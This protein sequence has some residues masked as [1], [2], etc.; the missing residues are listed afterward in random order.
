[1]SAKF[2]PARG[3][4]IAAAVS[5]STLFATPA[6]AL[7]DDEARRAILDLRAQVKQLSEQNQ[8]ARYQLADRLEMMQREIASMRGEI[9]KLRWEAD[10]AKRADQ[11]QAS[12][13]TIQTGN[14]DEQAAF[15]APMGLFQAGK[16]GEAAAGFAKFRGDYPSSQLTNEAIFYQG[17]SL[18]ATKDFKN[19]ISQLQAMVQKSP[20]DPRSPDALLIVAAAQIELN[21]M[22]G[23]KATLQ[24]IAQDYPQTSAAETAKS[25][26][27]LL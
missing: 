20:A 15:D 1:M 26:L 13:S 8:Q 2:S 16:Y 7:A 5:I 23:A 14:P 12:G 11:N 19:A 27:Q 4:L 3:A 9:E 25:R 6:H 22:N 18:Y 17:S 24:R 21:N 10:L